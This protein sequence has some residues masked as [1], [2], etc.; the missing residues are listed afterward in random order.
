[1]R[2]LIAP[3]AAFAMIVSQV[4]AKQRH[5]TLRLHT[6]AN[7]QDGAAFAT[8]LRSRFTGKPVVIEK[9]P[10]I[11]EHD[12]AA[13]YPY[14]AS[15]GSFGVLI[16]LDQHGQLALDTLSVEHR[17]GALF[18]FVN[19]RPITE[20]QIDRRIADGKVFIPSGL[21]AGDIE[22]MRRDWRLL[23]QRRK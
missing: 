3:L 17:G 23:G 18:V 14:P 9:I 12:V 6:E 22:L 21:T 20:L 5:C 13:F 4:A 11:S 10:T 19:G 7:A 2:G 8:P 1:M 15:D 16:Q